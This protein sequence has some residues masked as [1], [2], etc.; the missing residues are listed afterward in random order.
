M[1]LQRFEAVT[2]DADNVESAITWCYATSENEARQA[3]K[4]KTGRDNW[5][6]ARMFMWQKWQQQ[7]LK[8]RAK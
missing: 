1:T 7:G 2:F 5:N 3:F 8:V 4:D 6:K